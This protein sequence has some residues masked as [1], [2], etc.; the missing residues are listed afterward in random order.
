MSYRLNQLIQK[1]KLNLNDTGKELSDGYV[2]NFAIGCT[3]GC[4]FCYVDSI[5]KRFT[6][7][8]T[9]LL[10]N[11]NW[12]E[13]FYVAE[14]INELI[15]N[16]DFSKYKGKEILLSS[17]HDPY[18]PQLLPITEKILRKG[19]E[20]GARFCIQTRSVLALKHLELLKQYKHQVRVQTSIATMNKVLARKLE[21]FVPP[22]LSRVEMLKRFKKEGGIEV[23]V[24]VAP[25]LPLSLYFI[26]Q[27]I[28][29]I[30]AD[31]CF[32]DRVYGEM[33]HVRG[34]NIKYL[35]DAGIKINTDRKRLEELDKIVGQYFESL[36]AIHNLKGCYWYN[37]EEC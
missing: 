4:R 29:N 27:D 30:F 21:P 7:S 10:V 23:G 8:R 34:N 12:G 37:K 26:R 31:I 25:I 24:I 9:G 14:N 1:S 17:T 36:L 35:L 11:K 22:P 16:T 32:V 28:G 19:L 20:E 15:E 13:Y 18:L 2:I 5:H 33:L 6:A 3:H